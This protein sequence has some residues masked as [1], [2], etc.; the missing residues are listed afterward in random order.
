TGLFYLERDL[1]DRHPDLHLVCVVGDITDPLG[2]VRVFRDYR[3][4]RVFHAAAY[5]HVAMMELNVREALRNN[6]LGTRLVAEAAAHYGCE[7]FV[8]VSS[9][10]AVRPTSVMGATKRLS[11]LVILEI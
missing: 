6:V 9:D 4:S 2:V 8:L 3:P 1:R 11:E 7:K 10:K 5:K